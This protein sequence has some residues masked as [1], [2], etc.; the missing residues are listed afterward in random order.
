MYR[1]QNIINNK[2]TTQRNI[3]TNVEKANSNGQLAVPWIWQDYSN[4]NIPRNHWKN[5]Q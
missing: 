4:R 5:K 2:E 3:A 1:E